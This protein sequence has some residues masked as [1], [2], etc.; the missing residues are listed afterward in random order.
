M[1]TANLFL[2]GALSASAL[3]FSACGDDATGRLRERLRVESDFARRAAIAQYIEC[4]EDAD[5]GR[6]V[7][8]TG[9]LALAVA[10]DDAAGVKRFLDEGADPRT[11]VAGE[12]LLSIAVLRT[13]D[14]EVAGL[15]AAESSATKEELGA[16]LVAAVAA[17]VPVDGKK[18]SDGEIFF[19]DADERAKTIEFLIARGADV[20][21]KSSAGDSALEIAVAK[22]DGAT[23]DALLDRGALPDAGA[24]FAAVVA[25]DAETLGDAESADALLAHGADANAR[26]GKLPVLAIAVEKGDVKTAK[27]LLNRGADVNATI[28]AGK[29]PVSLLAVAAASG[30]VEMARLFL[31]RG[32]DATGGETAAGMP[33]VGAVVAKN[34][35]L[36]EMLV[37]RGASFSEPAVLKILV[38]EDREDGVAYV[39]G[40]GVVPG[41]DVLALAGKT[42]IRKKLVEAGAPLGQAL[43][44]SV[45]RGDRDFSEWLLSRG[46]KPSAADVDAAAERGS[47]FAFV[48]ALVNAGAPATPRALAHFL[49]KKNAE[50]VDFLLSRG[51]KPDVS[52]DGVPAVVFA[53]REGDFALMRKLVEKGAPATPVLARFVAE[54]DLETVGFLLAHGADPNVE[55]AEDVP[56]VAA[57]AKDG[58]VALARALVEAGADAVPALPGFI[59]RRDA[60]AVEFLRTKISD[61]SVFEAFPKLEPMVVFAARNR[62]SDL[63]KL[64]VEKGADPTPVLA[65]YVAAGDES[66]AEWLLRHRARLD[67]RLV[68]L[69]VRSG[70]TSLVKLFIEQGG[71]SATPALPGYVERQDET[72]VRWLLDKGADANAVS[73]DGVPV[74]VIAA[75]SPSVSIMKRLVEAGAPATLALPFYVM[76]TEYATVD[77]LLSKNADPNA[78]V[79]EGV[80]VVALAARKRDERILEK[81]VEAGGNASDALPY[82]L[83]SRL[84]QELKTLDF[85]LSR[86]A[87]ARMRVDGVPAVVIAAKQRNDDVVR[88]LVGKG[89]N[90]SIALPWF[91]EN[92]RQSFD[93]AEFLLRNGADANTLVGVIPMK[94]GSGSSAMPMEK[95]SPAASS[96]AEPKASTSPSTSSSSESSSSSE[97]STRRNRFSSGSRRSR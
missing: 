74:V 29:K 12:S 69:A 77:Y 55:V 19:S 56:A 32:A 41:A 85:L 43:T 10:L 28:V 13:H 89:A 36:T 7:D 58:N 5:A 72:M 76:K 82:Y 97:P 73:D 42:S 27:V 49:A 88:K 2:L 64:L 67:D 93:V 17:D 59:G 96:E 38:N 20:N 4:V 78:T 40:K 83:D 14:L 50:A 54:N 63:V 8:A 6:R 70:K 61:A 84:S 94:A 3:A 71:A 23:R 75:K 39:L 11:S 87:D 68:A 65:H 1:K 37:S 15:L 18:P 25:G 24:L 53:A 33:L 46:A 26:A 60:E 48:R 45:R 66:M 35:V 92:K 16:L 52:V 62:N 47:D 31:D 81:L 9:A 21:A 34:E 91:A 79:S 86:G 30:N 80:S 90:A 44:E 57:A 95:S 22:K 51:A